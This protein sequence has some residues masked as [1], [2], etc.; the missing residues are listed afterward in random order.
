MCLNDGAGRFTVQATQL[1]LGGALK[2]LRL[3][4]FNGD[5][6]L[7][8]LTSTRYDNAG[9]NISLSL[10]T[11]Q[12]GFLPRTVVRT[13]T[14][15]PELVTGDFNADGLTDAVSLE[16]TPT[17]PVLQFMP[18]APGGLLAPTYASPSALGAR[19]L[20]VADM[21]EDGDLDLLLVTDTTLGVY[22]NDGRGQFAA[23]PTQEVNANPYAGSMTV[24]DFTG[25]GY[26]D[27]VCSSYGTSNLS[28][29]PGTGTGGWQARQDIA[30]LSR[31][32]YVS[33]A[34]LDGDGDLD[35]LATNDRGIT[36]VLLNNGRGQFAAAS[37]ILIGFESFSMAEAADLN[38]DGLLDIYTGHS[39]YSPV[40]PHGIDL[41]FN[42]P[43]TVTSTAPA[44]VASLDL[45]VFPNPAHE[46][47]TLRLPTGS[48][49]T[50]VE[51]RD[52]LG[53]LV[54]TLSV[55]ATGGDTHL[56]LA[57]MVPG[58]YSLH[59]YS[60]TRHGIRRLQIE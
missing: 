57:G 5:G 47:V 38:G 42:H 1:A 17:G 53:R 40:T 9:I 45:A 11:G 18:G 56:S 55:P 44:L 31:S 4:D 50:T 60:A 19:A 58:L 48:G 6:H 33:S 27:A 29:V 49:A 28:L 52:A 20:G 14:I 54:R 23:G 39:V 13:L 22:L 25:D 26:A 46:H 41:F 16:F 34:D 30:V 59:A 24:G 37:A 7:D 2:T 36:Q 35:L 21:D 15:P 51:L 32:A 3:A 8:L 10:G 43:A 12:G